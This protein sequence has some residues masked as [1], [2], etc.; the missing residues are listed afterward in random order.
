VRPNVEIV[1]NKV[2]S[3]WRGKPDSP[4]ALY[5][6]LPSITGGVQNRC[7]TQATLVTIWCPGYRFDATLVSVDRNGRMRKVGQFTISGARQST[8]GKLVVLSQGRRPQGNVKLA[9]R[10]QRLRRWLCSVCRHRPEHLSDTPCRTAHGNESWAIP[11]LLRATG[12]LP[13][14]GTT[15]LQRYSEPFRHPIRPGLSLASCQLILAAITAGASRVTAGL[16]CAHAVAITPAGSMELIRSSV[17]IASGLPRVTVRSAPAIIFSRPAQRS[18]A[19][20]PA[21]SRSRQA[22][23][24]TESSDSSVASAAASVATGWSEPVPGRELHPL[25]PLESSPF[26]GALLRQP[27]Q[28]SC[29]DGLLRRS[30]PRRSDFGDRGGS[31]CRVRHSRGT[32]R[33]AREVLRALFEAAWLGNQSI[34]GSR[35]GRHVRDSRSSW[36]GNAEWE[37]GGHDRRVAP[38]Q[39]RYPLG[40]DR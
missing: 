16:L 9:K 17:S 5:F 8:V 15:R 1:E 38:R 6:T 34:F 29:S 30:P 7:S 12:P 22:T 23:L 21:R 28:R 35:G 37:R 40:P 20:R 39:G 33:R 4:T 18:L 36:R 31:S 25:H 11:S 32:V 13:Y 2:S 27:S 19:L 24:Y 14:T 10:L 26:H 3:A